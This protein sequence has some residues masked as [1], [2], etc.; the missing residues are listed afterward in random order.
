MDKHLGN[1]RIGCAKLGSEVCTGQSAVGPIQ[2]VCITYTVC[3]IEQNRYCD[4]EERGHSMSRWRMC[5]HAG[6][7]GTRG[8]NEVLFRCLCALLEC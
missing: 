1:P 4:Q 8:R 6:P 5:K 3:V 2:S 7:V